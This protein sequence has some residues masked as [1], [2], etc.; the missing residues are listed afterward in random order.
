MS[1][2][3]KTAIVTGA[4]SGIGRAVALTLLTDGY[5]VALA[6]RRTE[7]LEETLS[8]AGADAGRGIALATDVTD[9]DSVAA[10]GWPSYSFPC[11]CCRDVFYS[12]ATG[13]P[14]PTSTRRSIS[15]AAVALRIPSSRFRLRRIRPS[16]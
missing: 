6:G 9:P 16:H 5:R 10:F 4:G 3:D 14:L 8:A 13:S 2:H 1:S 15:K 7:K 12:L 11:S